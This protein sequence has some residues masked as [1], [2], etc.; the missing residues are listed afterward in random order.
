MGNYNIDQGS[1]Q[2]TE[3][4]RPAQMS[5][6]RSGSSMDVS[7][8]H[9]VRTRDAGMGAVITVEAAATVTVPDVLSTTASASEIR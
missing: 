2:L 8:V 3:P 9:Q 6:S 1:A 7:T 5:L 4:R